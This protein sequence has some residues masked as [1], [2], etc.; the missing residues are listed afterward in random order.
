MKQLLSIFVV[1]LL[2]AVA[3]HASTDLTVSDTGMITGGCLYAQHCCHWNKCNCVPCYEDDHCQFQP[4]TG[5]Y[6]DYSA[7]SNMC[8][9]IPCNPAI[10]DCCSDCRPDPQNPAV[11][12]DWY[13]GPYYC[14]GACCSSNEWRDQECLGYMECDDIPY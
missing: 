1:G 3:V 8:W 7:S 5:A 2:C 13:D 12:G 4:G 14:S 9:L 10:E 6:C 11:C